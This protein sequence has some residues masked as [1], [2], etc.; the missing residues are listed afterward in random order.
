MKFTVENEEPVVRL[1]EAEAKKYK[2][3]PQADGFS[4]RLRIGDEVEEEDNEFNKVV[5]DG[6]KK[7]D[8]LHATTNDA[9]DTLRKFMA[10]HP[11]LVAV[12]LALCAGFLL[13]KGL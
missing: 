13:A 9:V 12:V 5:E 2:I 6:S 11:I 4:I 1:T 10:E 7:K 3:S 8:V